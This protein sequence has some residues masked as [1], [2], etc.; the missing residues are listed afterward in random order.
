MVGLGL[1]FLKFLVADI[2]RAEALR[3]VWLCT[4]A[5][6]NQIKSVSDRPASQQESIILS[7]CCLLAPLIVN[8]R[9]TRSGRRL[10]ACTR[11]LR[12]VLVFVISYVPSFVAAAVSFSSPCH[13][14]GTVADLLPQKY[15]GAGKEDNFQLLGRIWMHEWPFGMEKDHQ[16][17]FLRLLD[18]RKEYMTLLF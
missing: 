1:V 14:F 2:T 12:Y 10:V 8:S 16:P 17:M 3:S 11:R 18:F 4:G 15:P 5:H 13:A 7:P 6:A 9:Q